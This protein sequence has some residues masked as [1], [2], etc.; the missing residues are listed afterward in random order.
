MS[1]ITREDLIKIICGAIR[2]IDS[3]VT[4]SPIGIHQENL[5]KQSRELA[6]NLS[7]RETLRRINRALADLTAASVYLQRPT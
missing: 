7:D 6:E 5:A 4:E 2:Q 3:A 1:V